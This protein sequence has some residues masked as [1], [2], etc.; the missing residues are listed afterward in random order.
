ME[1]LKD[2]S[3]YRDVHAE[4]VA[5]LLFLHVLIAT[6]IVYKRQTSP[7]DGVGPLGGIIFVLVYCTAGISGGPINPAVMMGL[8]VATKVPLVRA[9][10]YMVAQC[11]RVILV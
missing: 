7:C 10:A 1:E 6:V 3:F 9:V 11:L 5:T 4:F 8:F 2:W